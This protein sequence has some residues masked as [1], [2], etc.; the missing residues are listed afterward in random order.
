MNYKR[1]LSASYGHFAI[2][3]LNASIVMVLTSISG[4][5][6]LSVS[7]IGFASMVYT[8]TAA[9]TQPFFG[10]WADR[11]R[12]RWLG[13]VGVLWTMIFFALTP[14][15][16]SYG[17]LVVCLTIGALG[18]GALHASGMVNASAA[19]GAHPTTAT[20]IFFVMGQ[21]GLAL[22]PFLT[23]IL[24]QTIGIQATM[25]VM[26]L[27]SLPAV[28]MM[29]IFLRAPNEE[30]P[31]PP[32]VVAPASS[33]ERPRNQVVNRSLFVAIA[34]VLGVGLRSA[35]F[36]TF[37]TLL[38][39][40]FSDLG[41]EPA[42]YG[43]LLGVWSFGGALGTF[44]GGVLGDRFNRR[45]VI[46]LSTALSVPFTLAVLYTYDW[47]AFAAAALAGALL[48]VPH[49]IL[50]VMAQRFLPRRKGMMGGAV[51][52]FMFASGAVAAWVASWFADSLGLATVLTIVAF[53]PI[54][55]GVCALLLPSTRGAPVTPAP[56]RDVSPEAAAQ[57][58]TSAA[59]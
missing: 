58:V 30:E 59:D 27:L 16:P 2:D 19:G 56:T 44:A 36:T 20:S 57:P 25:P 12:G 39:K 9:L 41:F 15:M 33:A 38:P 14:F 45:M 1:L 43:A 42:V 8:V 40:Y 24:L 32:P 47:A 10:I 46:F 7:Q 17:A 34:F 31:Q 37:T 54:G 29:F 13:A 28:V 50:V 22:G 49:S 3:M 26:A 4:V 5:Y 48:N 51:L 21:M 35:S 52:G 18:S 53:L 55:A 6:A 23:G 11:L